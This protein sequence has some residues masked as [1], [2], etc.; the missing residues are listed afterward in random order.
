MITPSFTHSAQNSPI[1]RV[2][3]ALAL[4]L[5]LSAA[6][7]STLHPRLADEAPDQNLDIWESNLHDLTWDATYF[8]P[9]S[10]T[11]S[12]AFWIYPTQGPTGACKSFHR[13]VKT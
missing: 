11:R 9:H 7:E 2:V 10:R 13:D 8:E 3:I 6:F 12:I 1:M 4:L 5:A